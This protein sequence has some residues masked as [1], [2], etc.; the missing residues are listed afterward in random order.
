M[1]LS[2]A[3]NWS[4]VYEQTLTSGL[5]LFTMPTSLSSNIVAVY[6]LTPNPKPTWFTGAWVNQLIPTGLIDSSNSWNINSERI[7]LGK[8]VLI[9]PQSLS[10]YNLQFSFPAYFPSVFL[11]VWEYTGTDSQSSTGELATVVSEVATIVNN[12]A[13]IAEQVANL[14][15]IVNAIRALLGG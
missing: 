4:L 1:D 11:S 9:F 15:T 10:T 12:V 13:T 6:I 7:L 2:N 5:R 3:S 14:I 8:N